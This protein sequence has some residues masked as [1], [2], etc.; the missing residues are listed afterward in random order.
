LTEVVGESPESVVFVGDNPLTDVL[1][2]CRAGLR[3]AFFRR[4][5]FTTFAV[6]SVPGCTPTWQID[7]LTEL[8]GLLEAV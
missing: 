1:G 4:G 3:S 6:E 8:A 7:Y 2:A 5:A